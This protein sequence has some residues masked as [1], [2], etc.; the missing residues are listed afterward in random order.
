MYLPIIYGEKIREEQY[1][2]II[3]GG[4]TAMREHS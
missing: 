2:I 3:S 1:K 4:S